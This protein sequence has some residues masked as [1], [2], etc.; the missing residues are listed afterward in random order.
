MMWYYYSPVGTFII[1]HDPQSGYGL[2]HDTDHLGSYPL[3]E[4]AAQAVASQQTGYPAWDQWQEAKPPPD[5]DHWIM[6]RGPCGTD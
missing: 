1:A 5:L 6:V 4:A 3:P 2:W